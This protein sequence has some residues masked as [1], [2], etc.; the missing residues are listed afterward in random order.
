MSLNRGPWPHAGFQN[1]LAMGL[2]LGKAAGEAAD[3]AEAA[4]L[5]KG[6]RFRTPDG[7]V[8]MVP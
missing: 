4:R 1:A 8:K 7:R 5:P 3:R 2:E 6:T